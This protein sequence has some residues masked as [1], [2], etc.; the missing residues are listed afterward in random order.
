MT[1]DPHDWIAINDR[2]VYACMWDDGGNDIP[3]WI[4]AVKARGHRVERVPVGEAV[5]RHRAYLATLPELAG[6]TPASGIEAPSGRQDA[7]AA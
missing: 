1:E 2:G 3:G 5:R 7:P 6:L 4:E